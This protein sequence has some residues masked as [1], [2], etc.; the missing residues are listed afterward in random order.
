MEH[1]LSYGLSDFLMFSPATYHRLFELHNAA[2]WPAQIVAVLAA[3]AIV[4]LL[5]RP[6]PWQ[7]RAITGIL[8]AAWLFVGWAFLLDRYAGIFSAAPWLAGLF[9]LEAA[10]LAWAALA[11]VPPRFAV[12]G[13][14]AG[15][16]AVILLVFAL[17]ILPLAGPLN[18]RPW[19]GIQ[20]FGIAP[21]PTAAATIA[22]LLC[23]TGRFRWLLLA[24]PLLWCAVSGLTLAAMDSPHALLLPVFGL[25][26]L[27]GMWLARRA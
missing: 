22:L 3:L 11:P 19:T 25:L 23:G 6:P 14:A 5:L 18:G 2:V 24:I 21:D 20:L 15:R 9:L 27:A 10:L 26:A 12:T 8:A 1:W 4:A 13:D 16:L 7:G 17:A